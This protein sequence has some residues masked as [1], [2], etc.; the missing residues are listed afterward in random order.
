VLAIAAQLNSEQI[1][2]GF[3]QETYPERLFTWCSNLWEML[4]QPASQ[5]SCRR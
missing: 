2:T 5:R 3:L 1:G 4:S